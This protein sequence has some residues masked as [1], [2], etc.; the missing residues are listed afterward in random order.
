MSMIGC[1]RRLG[2]RDLARLLAEPELILDY[3]D[4]DGEEANGSFGPHADIDVDKA[5]HGIHFLLTGSAWEGEFPLSFLV[6][7][8]AEVGDEDVGYGPARGFDSAQVRAIAK[9]LA[10]IDG[11]AL[12]DRFDPAAMTR[13]EIYPEIWD[14]DS[15]EDDI[16]EYLVDSYETLRDFVTA[17]AEAGEALLVWVS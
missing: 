6:R 1:L 16:V 8:G 2:D 3:L 10:P 17:A 13:A 11:E 12:G 14:R 7:G 5:W 4:S 9:A 15:E